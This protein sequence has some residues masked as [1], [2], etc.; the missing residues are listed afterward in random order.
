[1]CRRTF[2]QWISCFLASGCWL[3]AGAW[4]FAQ[5]GG[6]A[7]P[8]RP[9]GVAHLEVPLPPAAELDFV[10]ANAFELFEKNGRVF[11]PVLETGKFGQI[12]SDVLGDGSRQPPS[13]LKISFLFT[14]EAPLELTILTP[15]PR[16]VIVTPA[17]P[18]RPRDYEKSLTK[19]WK[20]YHAV[21]RAQRR[22][23]DY[24][25]LV[26]AYLTSM[27]SGRLGLRPPLLTRLQQ[28][29]QSE[30]KQAINLLLGTEELR[31]A[32]MRETMNGGGGLGEA[33]TIP[34]PPEVAWQ[35]LALPADGP[36]VAV[37][38]IAW[39]VPEEC[40]YIRF[41]SFTNYLW[42]D[43]LKDD[44]GGDIGRMVTLRGHNARV[45]EKVQRQLALKQTALAEVMGPQVISDVALIGRDLYMREGPA[46]GM[47]FEAS[48]TELLKANLAG[49]RQEALRSA[50]ADGATLETVS[51]AGHDVSFL[52]T[53][54]HRLRSFHAIDGN[55]HLVTTSRAIVQRFYAAGAGQGSLGASPEFQH[56]R[57]EMPLEREDTIFA[58]FSSA[59]FRA[60][61]SP[62]YQIELSRR[63]RSVTDMELVQLAQLAAL[64]ES[65]PHA[66]VDELIAG[67]FLPRGFGRRAGGG[68]PLVTD[69][70]FFDPLRGA[71]GT[72][73][74]IPD[75]PL[76]AITRTEAALFHR[77][78]H[79]LQTQ[80][81]QMDPLMVGI[82]RF[83]LEPERHERIVIDANV[84][85]FAEEKYGWLLSMVG[86]S[87]DVQ[88][89]SD[90][91]DVITAQMSL[92]GGLLWPGIPAHHL[93]L[94]VQDIEPPPEPIPD[95]FL[96]TLK[97]LQTTPGY[98]GAWPQLGLLD[99]FPFLTPQPDV[100]GFSPLPFGLWRWQG[101]GFSVLS[102]HHNV[103]AE[104]A[105]HLQPVPNDNPAQIRIRVSDLAHS[106]LANWISYMNYGRAHQAS[107]GN[108]RLLNTLSQQL[109]IALPESMALANTLLDTQ[110]VCAL[111][112]TYEFVEDARGVRQWRSTAWPAPDVAPP[113][114][115]TA[116]L[117]EWFRGA[118][119]DLTKRGDRM[120]LH[121]EID[122]L[123]KE[124][125]PALK[126]PLFDLFGGKQDA[127]EPNN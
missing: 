25:P 120:F 105:N 44:Y 110:L 58:Y 28:P 84:S 9:F 6:E 68:P 103:L 26:Q 11:Y 106:R 67:G 122:M 101:G 104:A 88:I 43:H 29:D 95:G 38:P 46:L 15:Q 82:K 123:R 23:G 107:L 79:F 17:P 102:F 21:A 116:P 14:G 22:D 96:K 31:Y 59:F 13:R 78:A 30:L 119:V 33:A 48:N 10:R 32:V 63:L 64:A 70:G 41:G 75:M 85:P 92:Q 16:D 117:L 57:W 61:L 2:L 1:M 40:F 81:P 3:A 71:R 20:A 118:S 91:A 111:G 109:R 113:D 35:P 126:L 52:S 62:Q 124:R 51:I 114:E 50:E 60:L 125:E 83:A 86:P 34:V 65:R 36:Q 69:H 72:F 97:L 87:T 7:I 47:L 18:R 99:L 42:F 77:A 12:V 90:P 4:A 89:Q 94:G 76:T 19:W 112:G 115:Y 8:G 80:W 73:L 45:D 108:V 53:P 24:P 5:R 98:L 55:Y 66:T 39:H 127:E 37:E 121:A 100:F 56:A 54:D 93:F 49:D 27:L 74:P